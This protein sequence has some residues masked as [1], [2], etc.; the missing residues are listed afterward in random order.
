MILYQTNSVDFEKVVLRSI[1]FFLN[2][3]EK[4]ESSLN[5]LKSFG[6]LPTGLSKAS[7]GLDHEL[8]TAYRV[9]LP[10]Y[11][12]R[13]RTKK[14]E[15]YSAWSEILFGTPQESIL[16]PFLLIFSWQIFFWC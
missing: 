9:S 7:D 12:S 6:L 16:A 14:D 5:K 11:Q 3:L 4:W 1:I 13:K 8:L 15:K 10:S 2:L